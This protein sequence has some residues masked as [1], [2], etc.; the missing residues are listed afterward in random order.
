MAGPSLRSSE[1]ATSTAI[2]V[3]CVALPAP[4][5]SLICQSAAHEPTSF[6]PIRAGTTTASATCS[7]TA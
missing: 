2:T 5:L 7:I 3:P 1:S 6:Q 4:S